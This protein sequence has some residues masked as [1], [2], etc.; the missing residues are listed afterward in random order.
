LSREADLFGDI[1]HRKGFTLLT[2]A[3]F[4]KAFT[5]K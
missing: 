5:S 2:F 1:A 4:V 3:E